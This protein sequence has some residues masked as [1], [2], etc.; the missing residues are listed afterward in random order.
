MKA[1]YKELLEA[2]ETLE[3]ELNRELLL[4]LENGRYPV[5][6][7]TIPCTQRMVE[8][9]DMCLTLQEP[10]EFAHDYAGIPY[11]SILDLLNEVSRP[12]V[13]ED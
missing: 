5:L 4:A 2:L 10:V 12:Y 13:V 9:L 11:R 6:C 3:R 8:R 1:P 7:D